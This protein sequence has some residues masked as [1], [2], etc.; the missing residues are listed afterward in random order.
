M[1]SHI[2]WG[3]VVVPSRVRGWRGVYRP[4]NDGRQSDRIRSGRRW[5]AVLCTRAR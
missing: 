1:L 3:Q 2:V 4:A 5:R